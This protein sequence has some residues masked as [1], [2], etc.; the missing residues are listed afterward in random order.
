MSAEH[1]AIMSATHKG[2][3][4]SPEQIEKRI[5]SRLATIAAR[6]NERKV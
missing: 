1:R 3:K 5:A 2:K 6:K 4:Q